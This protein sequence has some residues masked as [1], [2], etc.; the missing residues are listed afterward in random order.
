MTCVS[1]SADGRL[2]FDGYGARDRDEP[3]PDDYDASTY[4]VAAI[5]K[6]VG[7]DDLL[8]DATVSCSHP[9]F[10]HSSSFKN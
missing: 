2:Q 5:L 10:I 3:D 8:L 4:D 9:S 7:L 1:F 6:A